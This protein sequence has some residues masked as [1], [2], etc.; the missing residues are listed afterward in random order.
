MVEPSYQTAY[1]LEM[2]LLGHNT[3]IRHQRVLFPKRKLAVL[4]TV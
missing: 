2:E 4:P 3:D 1:L